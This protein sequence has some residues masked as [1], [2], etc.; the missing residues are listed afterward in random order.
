MQIHDDENRYRQLYFDESME[1]R[2]EVRVVSREML[3]EEVKEYESMVEDS[4][5]LSIFDFLQD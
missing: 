5:Q 4:D 3:P 2:Q 1:I